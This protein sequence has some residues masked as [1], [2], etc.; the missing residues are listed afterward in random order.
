MSKRRNK[1]TRPAR[2]T[3]TLPAKPLVLV[4]CEG[5][6]T[7]PQYLRAFIAWCKNPRVNLAIV[8]GAGVPLTLV[9]EA[10]RRRDDAGQRAAEEKD[11]NLAYDEVWCVFDVDDHPKV[12]Q[13]RE[14]AL[15]EGLAVAVSNPCFELWLL[16]HFGESPGPQH[17]H[18]IQSRCAKQMPSTKEKHVDVDEVLKGY[19][20][21]CDRAERLER[22]A[23]E[24]G[25]RWQNPTTAVF[26]LTRS[27][28]AEGTALRAAERA[29][30]ADAERAARDAD[31][32]AKAQQAVEQAAA[33]VAAQQAAGNAADP[34]TSS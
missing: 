21:A 26:R 3:E 32:R 2:R 9:D 27:I 34:E 20:A 16:L 6:E 17:R 25:D 31:S 28:D 10:I 4:V 5:K 22:I 7:E 23:I 29:R 13:A 1:D 8:P 24:A 30:R 15:A 19:V 14:K 18:E 12:K 11:Q 33:L